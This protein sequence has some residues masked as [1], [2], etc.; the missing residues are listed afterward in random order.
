[1]AMTVKEYQE[2]FPNRPQPVPAEYAGKWLA[3]DA[4]RTQIVAHGNDMSQVYSEAVAAG[5]IEPLLQ[6]IP[7]GPFIGVS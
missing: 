6:K 7:R 3:W 5:H 2:R 1:M 4:K